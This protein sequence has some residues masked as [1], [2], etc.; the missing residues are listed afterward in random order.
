M[1]CDQTVNELIQGL[2]RF[3][4]KICTNYLLLLLKY[5]NFFNPSEPKDDVN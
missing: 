3:V 4:M 2:T 5:E 1:L